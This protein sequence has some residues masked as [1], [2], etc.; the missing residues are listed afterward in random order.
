MVQKAIHR[1]VIVSYSCEE[2]YS[3][4]SDVSAYHHFLPY[5]SASEVLS[6]KGDIV[7]G[8]MVFSYFG[9]TY[10]VVN[11]TSLFQYAHWFVPLRVIPFLGSGSSRI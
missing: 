9:L 2:M 3:L 6:S 7:H 5:C 4:V 1:N 10:T 11:K 8:Q